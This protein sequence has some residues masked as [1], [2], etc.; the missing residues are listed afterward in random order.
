MVPALSA[1]LAQAGCYRGAPSRQ[2][3]L[4]ACQYGAL[5]NANQYIGAS[6]VA[7]VARAMAAALPFVHGQLASAGRKLTEV[8]HENDPALQQSSFKYNTKTAVIRSVHAAV[9]PVANLVRAPV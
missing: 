5:V 1:C 2:A 6:Y 8:L 4:C 9:A 3:R 7:H